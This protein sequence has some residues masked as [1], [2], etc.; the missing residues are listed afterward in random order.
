MIQSVYWRDS[1]T[2]SPRER[3]LFE[4]PVEGLWLALNAETYEH[5]QVKA[6]NSAEGSSGAGIKVILRRYTDEKHRITLAVA[7]LRP[8]PRSSHLQGGV[9]VVAGPAL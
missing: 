6:C 9:I 5:R 1:L 4:G 3:L 2:T 7:R 8:R